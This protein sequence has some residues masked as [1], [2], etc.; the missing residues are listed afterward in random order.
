MPKYQL[1][2]A[3]HQFCRTCIQRLMFL[4]ETKIEEKIHCAVSCIEKS[5]VA[6]LV[7]SAITATMQ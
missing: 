7:Q 4:S 6:A 2:P 1:A 5:M 3:N